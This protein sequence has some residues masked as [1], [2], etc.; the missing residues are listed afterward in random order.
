LQTAGNFIE[1]V[2][3]LSYAFDGDKCEYDTA[4]MATSLAGDAHWQDKVADWR[5][6]T[7]ENRKTYYSQVHPKIAQYVLSLLPVIP[8]R[9]TSPS[10]T[11]PAATATWQS[12]S[13]KNWQ[14]RSSPVLCSTSWWITARPM[15]PSPEGGSRA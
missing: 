14:P 5:L 6:G 4:N 3:S 11:S 9:T 8:N 15:W 2:V 7:G 1:R 13:S 10:S 12:A